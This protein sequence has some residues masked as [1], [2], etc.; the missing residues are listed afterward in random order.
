VRHFE[1]VPGEDRRQS[2]GDMVVVLDEKQSHHGPLRF[3]GRS[4]VARR[5]ALTLRAREAH[6]GIHS[7]T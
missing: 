4:V 1:A 6:Q 5:R 3:I 7:E 2:S